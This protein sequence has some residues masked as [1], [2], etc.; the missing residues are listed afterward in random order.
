MLR[1]DD[2]HPEPARSPYLQRAPRDYLRG[3]R[4]RRHGPRTALADAIDLYA[5]GLHLDI[6]SRG[7]PYAP[8]TVRTYTDEI[9]AFG[10]WCAAHDIMHVG[11]VDEDVVLRHLAELRA[12]GRSAQYIATRDK[13]IRVWLQWCVRRGILT[14]DPMA[15]VR[16]QTPADPPIVAVSDQE[17]RRVLDACE[18]LPPWQAGRAAGIVMVLWRCGLRASEVCMLD[19]EDY[20]SRKAQLRVRGTK[21]L[22]ARRVVGV[23][24][25]CRYVL[26]DWVLR[27]R[28][29]R[30][31]PLFPGERT[32]RLRRDWL[33]HLVQR[34]GRRAEVVGLHPHR[35][36]HTFALNFLRAGGDLYVLM[37]LMGH[38]RIEMTARYLR[39][40]QAEEAA[41]THVRVMRARPGH[42]YG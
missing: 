20:Q 13:V 31:G 30:P 1:H 42:G 6:S 35:L 23:P 28:G 16:R 18:E 2:L 39:A 7:Q 9:T 14:A 5:R 29:P 32:E 33:T 4:V 3:R 34:L 41:A 26:D 40:L 10:A 11:D 19:L 37:R 15:G 17:M 22:A 25:D 12:R 36:R 8:S 27:L 21:S 24:D 38:S